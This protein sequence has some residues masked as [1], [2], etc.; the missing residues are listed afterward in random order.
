MK[1]LIITGGTVDAS[2]AD[3]YRKK[4]AFDHLIASDAGIHYFALSG[5]KP[6]EILGDFDSA[7]K[8]ELERFRKEKGIIFH[9]YQPEKDASDTELALRLALTRGSSEVHILGAT[10]TRLD[11]V[12]GAVHL[13]GIAL[14]AGVPCYM[15]DPHNRIRLADKRLVI[16]RAEQYGKYVSLLPVDG[17]VTGVTL[18]GFRYPLAHAEMKSFC[19]LGVSNEIVAD[20][21]VIEIEKGVLAVMETMD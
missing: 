20:E 14:K 11:H 19:T 8:E 5:L 10:G 6:D 12:F 2:F 9:P 13:L 4:E 21:A 16:K 17:T 3:A 18:K 1:T 15:A 7:D